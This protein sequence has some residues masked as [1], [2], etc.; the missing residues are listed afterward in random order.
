[1]IRAGTAVIAGRHELASPESAPKSSAADLGA[2]FPISG[3]PQI[4][5]PGMTDEVT[6]STLSE[7]V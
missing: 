7:L 6:G 3:K 1:M 4:G 5:G 2:V